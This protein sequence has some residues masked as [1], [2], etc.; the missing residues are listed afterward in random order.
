ML[1][2]LILGAD[3]Y[4]GYPLMERLSKKHDVLGLDNFSRNNYVFSPSLM[5]VNHEDVVYC[6]VLNYENLRRQYANFKPDIVIHLAEQRSAPF[7]MRNHEYKTYTIHNNV[8]G[9]LNVLECAKEFKAKVIHIGSMGMYGY[10]NERFIT[11]GD[12]IRQPGSIYHL[13]KEMDSSLFSFYARVHGVDSVD[14]NQGTV[15]GLGGRFDY[16]ELYGTVINRFIVQ[17]LLG[18]PLT[19]Y[20]LGEQQRSFI[21]IDNSIDCVELVL[22][23]GW[24]GY[25]IYNQFTEILSVN[26]IAEIMGG[27]VVHIDNPRIEKDSNVLESTN[28]KLIDLGLAPIFFTTAQVDKMKEALKP[29]LKRV[30]KNL[31]HPKGK[32][33]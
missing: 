16:D 24:K 7:S 9:T 21:H 13:T 6:D 17:S 29:Y 4:Y 14:L 12:A 22:E 3:G 26:K 20:G 27:E 19:V 10:E 5:P 32:W 8:V 33:T 28:Q 25:E 30:N 31:I 23:K 15:W 18:M 1:K 2:I 11:E